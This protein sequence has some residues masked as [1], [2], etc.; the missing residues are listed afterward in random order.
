MEGETFLAPLVIKVFDSDEGGI[1]SSDSVEFLGMAA[2]PMNDYTPRPDFGLHKNPE[3][4]KLRYSDTQEFGKVLISYTLHPV[5][6]PVPQIL[7]PLVEP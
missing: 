1:L 5:N 6:L 2:I 4:Y 7:G 3:W